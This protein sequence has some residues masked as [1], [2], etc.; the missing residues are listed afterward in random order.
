MDNMLPAKWPLAKVINTHPG[1][2]GLTRVVTVKTPSE[3]YKRPV[4]KTTLLLYTL[5]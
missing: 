2:Y 5:E 4:V 3:E 1:R